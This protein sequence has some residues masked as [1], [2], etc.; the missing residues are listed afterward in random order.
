MGLDHV[1]LNN[2]CTGH[3]VV[4][5]VEVLVDGFRGDFLAE[6]LLERAVGEVEADDDG[7]ADIVPHLLH[8][9]VVD[10]VQVIAFY[11]DTGAADFVGH[12]LALTER[13]TTTVA[14]LGVVH[15]DTAVH[16]GLL[17]GLHELDLARGLLK[18]LALEDGGRCLGVFCKL[19]LH[20][21]QEELLRSLDFC[22]LP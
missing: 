6:T 10:K 9:S 5:H 13:D 12:Q 18:T 3:C 16:L 20:C 11:K 7:P 22:F 21:L 1:F 17:T 2:G 8:G 15:G 14:A 19:L 4:Q